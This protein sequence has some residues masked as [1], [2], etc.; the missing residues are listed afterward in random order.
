MEFTL[1]EKRKEKGLS[2]EELAEKSGVANHTIV[3][4]ESGINNPSNAKLSTLIK[5]AKALKCKVR[6]FYPKEKMI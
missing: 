2:R 1:K 6:D 3:A 5:L 4:L